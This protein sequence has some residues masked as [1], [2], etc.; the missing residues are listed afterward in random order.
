M[1]DSADHWSLRR[2]IYTQQKF[3]LHRLHVDGS[4]WMLEDCE[5]CRTEYYMLVSPLNLPPFRTAL[6]EG[7]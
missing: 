7:V 1:S 3:D 5:Y 4:V 6:D 2:D